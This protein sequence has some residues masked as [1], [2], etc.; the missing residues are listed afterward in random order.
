MRSE[1]PQHETGI[2]QIGQLMESLRAAG[3]QDQVTFA[4][5]NVFG[6]TLKKNGLD[7]R[8]HWGSHHATVIMGKHVR[9]GVV[10]GLEPKAN[11]YYAT[12]I[13]SKTGAQPAAATSPSPRPWPPWARPWARRWA[14]PPPPSTA[15][16]PAARWSPPRWSDLGTAGAA[17]APATERMSAPKASAPSTLRTA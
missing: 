17:Q 12:P 7:G 10:G 16:S 11:D 9:A 1:V 15:T 8:D 4:A 14:S 13:D 2:A 5:Y 6:R 3:L